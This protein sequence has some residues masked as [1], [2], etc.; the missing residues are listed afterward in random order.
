[1]KGCLSFLTA[2]LVTLVSISS[3]S[4]PENKLV[5]TWIDTSIIDSDCDEPNFNGPDPSL[6]TNCNN[7]TGGYC[8]E[9]TTV[10]RDDNTFTETMKIVY[11]NT[12]A[13]DIRTDGGTYS[14]DGTIFEFCYTQNIK[15]CDS[16]E[17]LIDGDMATASFTHK[18]DGCTVTYTKRKL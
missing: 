4:K 7:S 6:S 12:G 2:L 14:F 9:I 17:F 15:Y 5:G 3:C 10:Y 13:E 8:Y 16:M 18:V 11:P 1:M